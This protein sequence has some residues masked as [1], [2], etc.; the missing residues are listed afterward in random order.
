MSK[1]RASTKLKLHADPEKI[2][3]VW[4]RNPLTRVKPGG[5]S[6]VLDKIRRRDE[7]TGET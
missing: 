4:K 7:R 2:R 3:R 6:D 1:K 5:R